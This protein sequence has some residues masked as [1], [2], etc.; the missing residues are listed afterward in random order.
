MICQFSKNNVFFCFFKLQEL[1]F[2]NYCV[3]SLDFEFFKVCQS[4]IKIGVSANFCGFCCWKKRRKK[5]QTMTTGISGL[6]FWCKNGRFV[7][8]ICFSKKPCR[9]PYFYSVFWGAFFWSSCQK[10]EIWTPTQKKLT[11]N[12]YFVCFCFSF[13]FLEGLRLRWGGPSGPPHL[14]LNPPYLVIFIGGVC[15]FFFFV[16]F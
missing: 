6:V 7:M 1:V 12:F 3:L 4:S 8:H 16:A 15:F 11:D 10:R 2:S 9:N 5:A 14:A 13:V